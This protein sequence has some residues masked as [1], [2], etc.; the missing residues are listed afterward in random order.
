MPRPRNNPRHQRNPRRTHPPPNRGQ[1]TTGP[2][3]AVTPFHFVKISKTGST[4]MHKAFLDANLVFVTYGHQ[5]QVRG[6]PGRVVLCLRDP[7]ARAVSAFNARRDQTHPWGKR[8]H[9]TWE[10]RFFA[11]Y[12]TVNEWA[13][14]LAAPRNTEAQQALNQIDVLTPYTRN[15]GKPG[16]VLNLLDRFLWVGRQE[17][18]PDTWHTL[19][20]T[21]GTELAL[22]TLNVGAPADPLTDT[23]HNT[24]ASLY[25]DDYGVLG[26]LT[27]ARHPALHLR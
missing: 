1:A 26:V 13:D 6:L 21:L 16:T 4:S 17:T 7:V 25:A 11:R 23:Q 3:L 20:E 2:N 14:A 12:P 10:A 27:A 9:S 5:K 24:I 22:P 19:Q 8:D 15:F 18:L